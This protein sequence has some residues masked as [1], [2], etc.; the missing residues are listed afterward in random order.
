M[1]LK[2]HF[3]VTQAVSKR[4]SWDLY[5]IYPIIKACLL[6]ILFLSMRQVGEKKNNVPHYLVGYRNSDNSDA[7]TSSLL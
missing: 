6:A 2:T 3:T 7:P 4:H 1:G 5:V